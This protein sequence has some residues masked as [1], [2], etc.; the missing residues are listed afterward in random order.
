MVAEHV[1]P[2]PGSQ[3]SLNQQLVMKDSVGYQAMGI[4]RVSTRVRLVLLSLRMFIFVVSV[5]IFV[6]LKTKHRN[7]WV[8]H[9]CDTGARYL[10]FLYEGN[11]GK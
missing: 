9:S 3:T 5:F 8:D 1:Q 4:T 7:F 6:S 10:L 2:S 11:N